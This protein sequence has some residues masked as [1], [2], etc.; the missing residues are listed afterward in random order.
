MLGTLEG[1]DKMTAPKYVQKLQSRLKGCFEEVC[2]YLKQQ[3]ER[4][5]KYYNLSTHGQAYKSG[6]L[7][8][9]MEKTRKKQVCPKLMPKWKGLFMVVRKFGTAY[10]VLVTPK[11]SKVYHYDLL[12]P[13]HSTDCPP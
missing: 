1:A 5:C 4:Q 3:G 6:D 8:Y 7:V 13:C 9:L 2:M 11:T 10:E 12:K